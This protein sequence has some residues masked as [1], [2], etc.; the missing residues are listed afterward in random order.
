MLW[1]PVG[2]ISVWVK[3]LSPVNKASQ[4]VVVLNLNKANHSKVAARVS[5][6]N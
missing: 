5:H 6:L 3:P 1:V 2:V 4:P